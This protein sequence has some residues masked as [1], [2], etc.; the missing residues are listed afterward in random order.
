MY[1]KIK[2][3]LKDVNLLLVEDDDD[4]REAIKS[5]L[6]HYTNEIYDCRDAK[7]A[8]E[9]FNSHN[10]NL[11]VSDIN[12]PRMSGLKMASIIRKSDENV[13]IIFLT[14]Y[15]NDENML[16]AIE[17][18]SSGVLKKPF[19]KR[20]LV[21]MMSFAANKFRSDFASVDLK[22][23]FVFN[24][25]TRELYKDGE[26]VALTKKEQALLHLFL[27]NQARTVSFEMIEANVWQGESCTSDTI[28]SFVYKLRKKLYPELIQ[29]AQGR[30]YKLCLNEECDRTISGVGYV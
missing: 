7:E 25:F 2:E 30:G 29:N 23:G 21:M 9:C 14:A 17:V 27:K 4:L 8:L 10:I 6:A 15:D 28:R 22:N 1:S 20:E 16:S 13:P 26:V 12:M 24:A 19:D 11:I 5:A 3:I 18:K